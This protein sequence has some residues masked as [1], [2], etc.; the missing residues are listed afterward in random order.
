MPYLIFQLPF[1]L[2][3]LIMTFFGWDISTYCLNGSHFGVPTY[4]YV[5]CLIVGLSSYDT[6]VMPDH[7]NMAFEILFPSD[8]EHEIRL[9]SGVIPIDHHL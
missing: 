5:A 4:P 2:T 9:T 3:V 8:Q 6:I 1:T 7:E